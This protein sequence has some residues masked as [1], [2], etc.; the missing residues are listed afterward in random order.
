MLQSINPSQYDQLL[1]CSTEVGSDQSTH[2]S[3]HVVYFQDYR[4]GFLL[5]KDSYKREIM[6]IKDDLKLKGKNKHNIR[7]HMTMNLQTV[8]KLVLQ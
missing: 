6:S 2:F 4:Y 1:C 3:R 8:Y 7:N 5:K